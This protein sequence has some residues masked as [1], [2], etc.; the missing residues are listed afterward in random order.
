MQSLTSMCA[1]S[2]G[3]IGGQSDWLDLPINDCY[4]SE[5]INIADAMSKMHQKFC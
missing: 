5:N 4:D 2:F 3:D 1:M